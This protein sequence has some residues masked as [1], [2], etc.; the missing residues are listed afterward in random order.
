[1]NS[2]ND[3]KVFTWASDDGWQ[4]SLDPPTTAGVRG[5]ESRWEGS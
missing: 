5:S 3:V 4:Y 1:M 2:P